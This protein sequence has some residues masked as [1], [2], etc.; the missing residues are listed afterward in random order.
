MAVNAPWFV[1]KIT[2]QEDAGVEPLLPKNSHPSGRPLEPLRVGV[3]G[4]RPQ[5][6]LEKWNPHTSSK[7]QIPSNRRWIELPEAWVIGIQTRLRL[8]FHPCGRYNS[9][10]STVD[11]VTGSLGELHQ[12]GKQRQTSC[13]KKKIR[14]NRR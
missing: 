11:R 10:E 4:L 5:D 3:S 13:V 9:L 12:D 14:S 8:H 2:I 7:M 6:S 1:R